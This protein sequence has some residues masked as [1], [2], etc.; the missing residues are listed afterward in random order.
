VCLDVS[1]QNAMFMM[2]V[3]LC[4]AAHSL[5]LW[6][7]GRTTAGMVSNL[8][9]YPGGTRWY[10]CGIRGTHFHHDKNACFVKK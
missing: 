4:G 5:A 1:M 10:P 9:F 3:A 6:Q 2:V 8:L 7:A